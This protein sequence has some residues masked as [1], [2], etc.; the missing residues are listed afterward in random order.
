MKDYKRLTTYEGGGQYLKGSIKYQE[1]WG[2]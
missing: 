1:N 2:K